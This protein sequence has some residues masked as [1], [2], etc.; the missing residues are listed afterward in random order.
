MF[1]LM[2]AF[3]AAA[4]QAASAAADAAAPH[5]ALLQVSLLIFTVM[6]KLLLVVAVYFAVARLVL[7]KALQLLM[8]YVQGSREGCVSTSAGWH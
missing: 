7:P 5:A 3:G 6:V 4:S 8:R 1:A 2:P